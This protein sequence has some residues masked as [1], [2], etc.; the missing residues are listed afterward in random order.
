MKLLTSISI[1]IVLAVSASCSSD[2]GDRSTYTIPHQYIGRIVVVYDTTQNIT[3]NTKIGHRY[4]T[5][6]DHG[7]LYTK[8]PPNWGAS[9]KGFYVFT[10]IRPSGR[11]DTLP[12]ISFLQ[13]QQKKLPQGVTDSTVCA[14]NRGYVSYLIYTDSLGRRHNI[15]NGYEF[16]AVDTLK[17]YALYAKFPKEDFIY[18]GRNN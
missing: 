13:I 9:F 3:G 1:F 4:Y 14:M 7:I 2:I 8:D 17:N 11:I 18:Y 12:Y 15:P 6:P 5:I 16:Y 10:T